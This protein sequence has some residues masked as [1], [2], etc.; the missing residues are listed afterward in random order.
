MG[1]RRLRSGKQWR[2]GAEY[3][4]N[5]GNVNRQAAR[6]AVIGCGALSF[7][8]FLFLGFW[9]ESFGVCIAGVFACVAVVILGLV[10]VHFYGKQRL[11]KW[12]DTPQMTPSSWILRR[13]QSFEIEYRQRVKTQIEMVAMTATFVL[14]ESA[15]YTKG[16]DTVTVTHDHELG[17][18]HA[19]GS[20]LVAGTE[21]VQRLRF[22]VH[23]LAIHSFEGSNNKLRYFVQTDVE[24]P[25]W[26]R[27][28]RDQIELVVE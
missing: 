20:L 4:Y 10:L 19:P 25:V 11:A 15:T 23:P 14:R 27:H 13:G 8:P 16:T 6:L 12:L 9:G 22:E 21:L 18:F 7:I 1:E 5:F 2:A 3:Q 26:P 24:L 17:T 28:Y